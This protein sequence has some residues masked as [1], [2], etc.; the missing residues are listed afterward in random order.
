MLLWYSAARNE[1][2]TQTR[3]YYTNIVLGV[4]EAPRVWREK[5]EVE[6]E[7]ASVSPKAKG[8]GKEK[9]RERER[10]SGGARKRYSADGPYVMYAQE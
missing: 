3:R 9:E 2:V 7:D 6:A 1:S 4:P 10:G 8:K 5:W